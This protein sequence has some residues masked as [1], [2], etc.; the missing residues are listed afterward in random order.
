MI[1][2]DIVPKNPE[3]TALLVR[4]SVEEAKAIRESARRSGRTLSGYV[5]HCLRNRLKVEAEIQANL[6][7]IAARRQQRERA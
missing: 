3:R 7:A 5:L 1:P 4:C 2:F 6:E